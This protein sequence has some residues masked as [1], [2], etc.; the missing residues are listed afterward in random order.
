ME[1]KFYLSF[2]AE[3]ALIIN[4][5]KIIGPSAARETACRRAVKRG[6]ADIWA[7][8]H[9]MYWVRPKHLAK[10]DDA[11]ELGTIVYCPPH[12]KAMKTKA[13]QFGAALRRL[14]QIMVANKTDEFGIFGYPIPKIAEVEKWI[15]HCDYSARA[16]ATRKGRY[17]PWKRDAARLALD[18]LR[19][20][21]SRKPTVTRNGHFNQLIGALL[22]ES[23][24]YTFLC[25]QA[26]REEQAHTPKEI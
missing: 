13:R 10:A 18:L 8:R 17:E 7:S 26:L 24:D 21:G 4:A 19:K 23:G 9:S 3:P 25:K 6:L 16:P 20:F 11:P 5:M 14:R 1:R 15:S 12:T 2:H 22:G